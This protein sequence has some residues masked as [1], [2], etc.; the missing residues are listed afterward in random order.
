M[1]A[2]RLMLAIWLALSVAA[3][4]QPANSSSAPPDDGLIDAPETPEQP[5]LTEEVETTLTE[6]RRIIA[7]DSIRQL[8]RF[9][10]TQDDF[11]SNLGGAET[12]RHWDLMR[13]TGFNPTTQLESVL[14]EPYGT[15]NVDGE[16]WFIWPYLDAIPSAELTPSRMTAA[17]R[18]D[19]LRLLGEIGL[20]RLDGRS[21]YPGVR[22]AIS[23]SGTWHYFLHEPENE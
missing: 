17:A 7:A 14:A 11:Q 5:P 13:R 3:C 4:G 18:A 8:A 1:K 12:F 6:L 2:T 16:T 20:A 19:A 15:L 21:G 9:A 10:A 23:E 22:T